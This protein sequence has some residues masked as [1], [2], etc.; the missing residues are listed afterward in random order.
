MFWFVFR[1]NVQFVFIAVILLLFYILFHFY[2]TVILFCFICSPLSTVPLQRNQCYHHVIQSRAFNG[3][4][5]F[6]ARFAFCPGESLL[7]VGWNVGIVFTF[8]TVER[9][10]LL[11]IHV[12]LMSRSRES[13]ILER[14][15][16]ESD[17]L[18]PTLQLCWLQL[19]LKMR[20]S[21]KNLRSVF[22][23]ILNFSPR[24][25]CLCRPKRTSFHINRH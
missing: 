22:W 5:C 20:T 13:E 9:R 8:T 14:S 10:L 19:Y 4:Q 17:I 16:L 2:F 6:P 21:R 11:F 7:L 18:P 3:F 23:T 15:E 25:W 12:T 24:Q 1:L